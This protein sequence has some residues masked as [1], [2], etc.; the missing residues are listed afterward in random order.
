ME[1]PAREM[2]ELVGAKL[3]AVD[4]DPET[5]WMSLTFERGDGSWWRWDVVLN[6]ARPVEKVG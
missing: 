2:R 6:A 4:N 5:G 1:G 3:A